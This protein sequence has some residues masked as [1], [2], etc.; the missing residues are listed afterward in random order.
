MLY[1]PCH[2]G[3]AGLRRDHRPYFIKKSY[4]RF[5]QFYV[6]RYLSPQFDALGAGHTFMRPWYVEI[7]GAPIRVGKFANVIAAVDQRVRLSVWAVKSGRGRIDIGDFCLISPGVRI[8]SAH[9]IRIADNCMLANGVYLTD[10]D[11]HDLY[12]RTTMGR[13][14]PIEIGPNV[15]VGDGA[16]VC[17]GVTVGANS[18][19]GA[20]AVVVQSV[21]PNSVAAG[22]PAR[23]VK[24]L[25]PEKTFTTREQWFNNPSLLADGLNEFDRGLLGGNTLW[26]WLRY[27]LAPTRED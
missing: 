11:W 12:N 3:G 6:R 17:K 10:S 20:G 25:D 24:Q 5:Q 13:T 8:S 22:N 19:I 27:L 4:L 2:F 7:F 21:P 23:V 1:A 14:A 9:S 26:H 18:I 15:W 16:V